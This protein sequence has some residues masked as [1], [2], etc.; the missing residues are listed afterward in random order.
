MWSFRSDLAEVGKAN[1]SGAHVEMIK[2]GLGFNAVRF[3]SVE[4]ILVTYKTLKSVRSKIIIEKMFLIMN[5][6][7][8]RA[9][10]SVNNRFLCLKK[11]I[12]SFIGHRRFL[13]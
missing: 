6:D 2:T 3:F 11:M 13:L 7:L 8:V 9:C 5:V 4:L 1:M 12:M 10:S